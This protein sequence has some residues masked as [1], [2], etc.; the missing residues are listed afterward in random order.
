MVAIVSGNSLGLD[1]GS[2]G[3]LGNQGLWGSAGQGNGGE[4]VYVNAATGNLV[5]QRRDEFL[6]STGLDN[7][8][9]RTYNSL[10]QFT[11]ETDNWSLGT[12][13]QQQLQL[14]GTVNT[15]GSTLTRTARDGSQSTYTWDAARACYLCREGSG[16]HDT[17]VYSAGEYSRTDGSTREVEKYTATGVSGSLQ[18]VSITD[19]DGN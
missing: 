10:G 1:L 7:A 14:S 19:A 12:Y 11:G 16:A 6:A 2:A 9:I 13:S 15:A 3:V 4:Q 8:A 17:I 18:L 5:V